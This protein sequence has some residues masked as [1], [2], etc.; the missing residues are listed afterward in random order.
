[1]CYRYINLHFTLLYSGLTMTSCSTERVL[2]FILS[3][4]S[5]QQTPL[6]LSTRAPLQTDGQQLLLLLLQQLLLPNVIYILHRH[7]FT[8]MCRRFLVLM[9][10]KWLKSVHIYRSYRKIKTGVLLFGPLRRVETNT[11]ETPPN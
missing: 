6:S 4:S 8:F 3:N 9:V 7:N 1:M 2:S 5:I 11:I 10:K